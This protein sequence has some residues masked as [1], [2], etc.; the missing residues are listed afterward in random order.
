[1]PSDVC[2]SADPNS[3]V[4]EDVVDQ[5]LQPGS[6]AR[7]SNDAPVKADRKHLRASHLA[8]PPQHVEGIATVLF[9]FLAGRE[10]PDS[11]KTH[12]VGVH[13]VGHDEV[14]APGDCGPVGKIVSVGVGVVE[15]PAVLDNQSSSVGRVTPR[16]PAYGAQPNSR[17]GSALPRPDELPQWAR[18]PTGN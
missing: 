4:F 5:A 2:P 3:I 1:M 16:V 7:T 17:S 8:L 10:T 6:S 14:A 9:P 11:C 18:Q 13:R 15:E 12:V